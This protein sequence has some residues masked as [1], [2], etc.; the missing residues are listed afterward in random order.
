[1]IFS[2]K[3]HLIALAL[4][5]GSASLILAQEVDHT[6]TIASDELQWHHGDYSKD[7]VVG[8]STRKAYEELLKNKPSTKIV[9]AIID[10]GT[11]SFHPDLKDNIWINTDEI[12]ANG[13]DDDKNGY[14]D[15][16][17]GWSF[18]GGKDGDVDADLLEFT[19]IYKDLHKRFSKKDAKSI[20]SDDAKDYKRYLEMK[21]NYESRLEKAKEEKA[22]VLGLSLFYEMA[23]KELC[24]QLK[25]ENL[26]M[27]DVE[28]FD[29]KND[30]ER[31]YKE[32]MKVCI[33]EDLV[34]QMAEWKKNADIQI[35]YQLS[36]DYDPRSLVG[37]NYADTKEQFY[38]NNHID[39][40]SADHGTHVAGI[41]G[42]TRNAYGVDGVCE[43]VQLMVIRCVPNGDERDKDVANAI[44]Y[45]VDNGARVINMSFGKSYSPQKF[46]VDEAVRY[47]ESK[48]VLLVHAAG[49]DSKNID[50]QANF[51]TK[52]YE[53]GKACSTWIEVGASGPEL[54][55]L[56]AEFTNYGVKEVDVFAP[57][58]DIYASVPDNK[59]QK[60]SGTSMASPVT[61]GVAA[62]ILSYYPEL[63]AKDVKAIILQSSSKYGKTKVVMPG[64][65]KK[66]VKF[67]K[68][69][70]TGGVVNLYEALKLASTWTP[71]SAK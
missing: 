57:G 69:S 12:P 40:P 18:I 5:V 32:F 60:N 70:A 16:V 22:Q 65:P 3:R 30:T 2:L 47:A 9:V 27:A 66:K 45:A 14:I 6:K 46:A 26:T 68:L 53:D 43:N 44:R 36:L 56:P 35:K 64:S 34:S 19:R 61:A 31:Q 10:S 23:N 11:E 25:K 52:F 58:V 55:T 39:G 50:T 33:Q 63:T 13:I 49:N 8:I 71:G 42:A 54:K 62:T 41:V 37:D 59:Y 4:T 48:G 38:G 17:H 21:K 15:D 20:A 7:G 1:M 28:A 29:P 67:K 24:S 51:P